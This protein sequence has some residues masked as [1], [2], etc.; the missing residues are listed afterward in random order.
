MW[1]HDQV[2]YDAHKA[3]MMFQLPLQFY[4]NEVIILDHG[5][6]A[7]YSILA[8]FRWVTERQW[9]MVSFVLDGVPLTTRLPIGQLDFKTSSEL[10]ETEHR[11]FI[12]WQKGG[13]AA[14]RY[15][16]RSRTNSHDDLKVDV[17]AQLLCKDHF[18]AEEVVATSQDIASIELM[19]QL[20]KL[21]I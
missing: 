6:E 1:I 17:L 14:L 15:E 13:F 3:A 10:D 19:D 9:E 20:A 2:V 11:N 5:G 21:G 18:Y 8:G 4:R 7:D 16:V 12:R